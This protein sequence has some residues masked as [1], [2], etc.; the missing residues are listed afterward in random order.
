[1][2][3]LLINYQQ[4]KKLD[5]ISKIISTWAPASDNND[6]NG[7]AAIVAKNI[8]VGVTSTLPDLSKDLS[9][10][11]PLFKFIQAITQV[12]NGNKQ[13][14]SDDIILNGL[15]KVN[16]DLNGGATC[17][18]PATP[19]LPQ[20]LTGSNS[21]VNLVQNLSSSDLVSIVGKIPCNENTANTNRCT[22]K[23]EYLDGLIAL[24]TAYKAKFGREIE[25]TSSFRTQDYQKSLCSQTGGACAKDCSNHMTGLAVDF[26]NQT[27]GNCPKEGDCTST[28]FKWLKEN[29]SKY[30]LGFKNE[31]GNDDNIHWSYNGH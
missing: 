28:E 16:Q 1:M 27:I 4:N 24:N 12:E 11:G 30:G 25:V 19:Y 21:C 10:D 22:V 6:P 9:K 31:L 7:Y 18:T 15:S 8:G 3:K 5:T 14:Y 20:S 29:G 17:S 26:T 13:A 23:K 2:G